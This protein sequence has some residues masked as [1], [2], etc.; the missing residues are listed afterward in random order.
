MTAKILDSLSMAKKR[1][2]LLWSMTGLFFVVITLVFGGCGDFGEDDYRGEM[3]ALEQVAGDQDSLSDDERLAQQL[4]LELTL[5]AAERTEYYQILSGIHTEVNVNHSVEQE[6]AQGAADPS[7]S[8]DRCGRETGFIPIP[9]LFLTRFIPVEMK[10]LT[11][12]LVSWA[13]DLGLTQESLNDLLGDEAMEP[14][15]SY[16]LTLVRVDIDSMSEESRTLAQSEM[17]LGSA[18]AEE[19]S[20]TSVSTSTEETAI[21]FEHGFS[22]VFSIIAVET[23][24]KLS[25]V[26]SAPIMVYCPHPMDLASENQLEG[27]CV[28]LVPDDTSMQ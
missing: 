27:W 11:L 16:R 6:N 5:S 20:I 13:V 9:D 10:A 2:A 22:Y 14:E 26:P 17:L 18:S 28:Q 25:S 1:S 12:G 8:C 15:F 4:P 24:T 21:T 7:E 3:D 23:N 19:V